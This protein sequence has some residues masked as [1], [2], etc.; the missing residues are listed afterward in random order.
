MVTKS[1]PRFV[2]DLHVDTT[3]Q[4]HPAR[5]QRHANDNHTKTN[6]RLYNSAHVEITFLKQP[7]NDCKHIY[8]K[9]PK[10]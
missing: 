6:H 3:K 7:G 9:K 5:K 4:F 2:P 10:C 1:K 8:Y